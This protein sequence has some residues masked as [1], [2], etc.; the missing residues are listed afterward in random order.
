MNA[1][2][3]K[4]VNERDPTSEYNDWLDDALEQS[5]PASDPLPSF[6]GDPNPPP[7]ATDESKQ[8]SRV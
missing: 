4:S 1:G 2:S 7:V 6:R 5:F 8:G 3:H